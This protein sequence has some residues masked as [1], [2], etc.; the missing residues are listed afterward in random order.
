MTPW[1]TRDTE[2]DLSETNESGQTVATVPSSSAP[3]P[4][5]P[6]AKPQIGLVACVAFGVGTTVGGGVF[7][8]SGTAINLAGSGA[9]LSY[10]IAGIVM[11]LC[12]LSFIVVSTRAEDGESGYVWRLPQ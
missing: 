5:A 11:A 9:V 3:E 7:T 6:S 10:V 4:S 12:A 2:R 8:L 1:S